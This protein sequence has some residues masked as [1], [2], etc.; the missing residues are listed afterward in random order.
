M[1]AASR[2]TATTLGLLHRTDTIGLTVAALLTR[3]CV[4]AVTS[5]MRRKH[6][7]EHFSIAA[8]VRVNTVT[9]PRTVLHRIDEDADD[10]A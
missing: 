2:A 4:M 5:A 7:W 9:N 10:G 3:A 1:A 8:F 6:V